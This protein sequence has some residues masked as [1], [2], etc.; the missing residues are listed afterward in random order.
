MSKNE[1]LNDI[2]FQSIQAVANVAPNPFLVLRKNSISDVLV[3]IG[4]NPKASYAERKLRE[5]FSDKNWILDLEVFESVIQTIGEVQFWMM[6]EEL[7]I[8]IERI[9]EADAKTP[10]FRLASD[11]MEVRFEVKTFSIAGGTRNLDLMAETSFQ[12]QVYLDSQI[13]SGKKI[14]FAVT[15]VAP[16]GQ[17]QK[18]LGPTTTICRKLI[19]K[20]SQNIKIDQYR[21]TPTFLVLNLM[22]ID[23][24]YTGNANLRPIFGSYPHQWSI[25]TGS[26]WTLAFGHMEQTIHSTPDFEGEPGIEGYLEKLGILADEQFAEISGLI[27]IIHPMSA[28]PYLCGFI[29]SK[30]GE[31]EIAEIFYALTKQNWNDEFDSNG[32]ALTI[33]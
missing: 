1:S 28:D 25:Q 29:R 32:F 2:F 12:A 24:Y 5:L 18:H 11:E 20:T 27:L 17:K 33:P 13:K 22:L 8:E 15:E 31:T 23:G 6:A 19:E 16:H 9:P 4:S 26:Y 14:A 3:F 7:G 10:D 30:D 21:G